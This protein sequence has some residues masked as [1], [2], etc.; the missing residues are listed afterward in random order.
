MIYALRIINK[1]KWIGSAISKEY[2][3]IIEQR[4]NLNNFEKVEERGLF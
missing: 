4:I 1:R 3:D 2:C